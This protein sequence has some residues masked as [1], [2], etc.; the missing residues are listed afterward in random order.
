MLPTG[1]HSLDQQGI[2]GTDR[3]SFTRSAGH[4]WYR[5]GII[6]SISKVFMVPTRNN[7]LEQQRIYGTDKESFTRI[8]G[9]DKESFTRSAGN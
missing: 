4:L 5:Q 6:H 8:Y 9:S 3:E 7:S 2:Y 1:N